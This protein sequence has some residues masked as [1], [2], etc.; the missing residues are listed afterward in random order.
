VGHEGVYITIGA[1]NRLENL[2]ALSL[3]TR[4]TAWATPAAP[5]E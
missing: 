4:D 1:E 3:V 5:W 2:R